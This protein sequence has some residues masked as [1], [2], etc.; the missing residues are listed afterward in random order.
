MIKNKGVFCAFILF[1]PTSLWAG[2]WGVGSF[3]ND[4]ALDWAY[5][6]T[7]SR[8]SLVIRMAFRS[9][10]NGG[11]IGVDSCSA[12]MAAAEVV[13]ALKNKS[14]TSLPPEVARWVRNHYPVYQDSLRDKALTAIEACVNKHRSELAQQ[15]LEAAPK[16]WGAYVM[17]L[18]IKLQ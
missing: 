9:L 6:L 15:W 10:P 8:S 17:V 1:I 3:E 7:A 16:E 14:T 12:A 11:D 18:K 5:E 2:G 4:G 13:A